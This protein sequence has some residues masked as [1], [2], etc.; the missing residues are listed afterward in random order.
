MAIGNLQQFRQQ[1]EGL[2]DDFTLADLKVTYDFGPT[3]LTSVT[4]YT[5]RNVLVLRDATQLS[6]EPAAHL[7]YL[8]EPL[9]L[10]G[11]ISK[12]S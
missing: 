4:S 6:D 9:I 2:T 11:G 12:R 7:R 8:R 5:H 3:T 1:H 10:M